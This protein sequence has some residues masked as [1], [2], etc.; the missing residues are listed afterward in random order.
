MIQQCSSTKRTPGQLQNLCALQKNIELVLIIGLRGYPLDQQGNQ[1][2][3]AMIVKGVQQ[4]VLLYSSAMRSA[5]N[6]CDTFLLYKH[7]H[8]WVNT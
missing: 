8:R 2:M 5:A 3:N 6:S 1:S 4:H 7:T